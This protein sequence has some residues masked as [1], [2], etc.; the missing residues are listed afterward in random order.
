MDAG[1]Q[2]DDV[3]ELAG[4]GVE[5]SGPGAA[6]AEVGPGGD[7]GADSG[8]GR[9]GRSDHLHVAGAIA[10]PEHG[11]G[12]GDAAVVV[13]ESTLVEAC[14]ALHQF[15]WHGVATA[16]HDCWYCPLCQIYQH[17]LPPPART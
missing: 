6:P 5:N 15:A 1:G 8:G 2:A 3:A 7:R 9:P 10:E 12:H 17:P 16:D 13:L 11:P 14:T 4:A